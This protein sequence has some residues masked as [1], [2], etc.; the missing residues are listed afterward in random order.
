VSLD[1]VQAAASSVAAPAPAPAL[2]ASSG[3]DISGAMVGSLVVLA[4]DF[5]SYSD[6][7]GGPLALG[8]V[9]VVVATGSRLQVKPQ[10]G[11]TTT[12]WY[13]RSVNG[14]GAMQRRLVS[15]RRAIPWSIRLSTSSLPPPPR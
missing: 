11:S 7:S 12:W 3:G 14:V 1:P 15:P 6:A 2:A 13:A 4:P 5:A 9:G 8:Q 10:S